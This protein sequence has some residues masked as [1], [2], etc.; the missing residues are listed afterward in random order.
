M[1]RGWARTLKFVLDKGR[2]Y[3]TC[4]RMVVFNF[5]LFHK[6][7][8]MVKFV[9]VGLVIVPQSGWDNRLYFGQGEKLYR[10]WICC[11]QHLN[12]LRSSWDNGVCSRLGEKLY[13][14]H[15]IDYF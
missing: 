3:I 2:S 12:V 15:L 6:R 13:C 5:E 7:V 14:L 4:I 10:L 8:K 9:L 11:F 1:S